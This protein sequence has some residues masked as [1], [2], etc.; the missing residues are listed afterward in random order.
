MTINRLGVDTGAARNYPR[1]HSKREKKLAQTI[2]ED[3]NIVD[4]FEQ[5]PTISYADNATGAPLPAEAA[6]AQVIAWHSGKYPY[7]MYYAAVESTGTAV[8]KF[9][10][11]TSAGLNVPMDDDQTDGPTAVEIGHGT[12]ARSRACFTVGASEAFYIEV[13]ASIADISDVT[14]LWCGFRKMEAYQADPDNYDEAATLNVGLG[15]DGRFNI[16]TILNN[17]A[18]STTNTG[19]T[20]WADAEAHTLRVEVSK[21]GRCKFYV[22]GTESTAATFSFDSG[23]VVVPFLHLDGETGDAGVNITSWEVGLL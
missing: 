6:A 15:A 1:K 3:K 23:E 17:A 20:A 16:T 8:Y 4:T 9:P 12:T 2:R 10:A 22:D 14:E 13:S 11:V 7:E 5:A 18:T 19:V 21:Q